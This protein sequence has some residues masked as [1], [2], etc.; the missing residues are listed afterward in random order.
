VRKVMGLLET[1]TA[2]ITGGG[3]GVGQAIAK[4]FHDEGAKVII[5]GRRE[6]KL[7]KAGVVIAPKGD[8][9]YSIGVDVTVDDD[10][11]RLVNFA[12]EK[13]GRI[14]IL[15]NNAAALYHG[16]LDESDPSL[17]DELMRTNAYAP[18]RLMVAVLPEMRKVGGGSI[19]NISSLAGIKAFPG[20]GLYGTSKAALQMLSQV[21]AME[22][23]SDNIRV[24]ILCP[25]VIKGTDIYKGMLT[26][27]QLFE[28]YD[29]IRSITP[30]GRLG[31]PKD[32]AEA[33]LFLASEQSSWVTGTI[34][35]LDG[36]R[37]LATNRPPS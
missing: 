11:R 15:V 13:T 34:F 8:R 17:W 14:D 25:A 22:V 4:R 6:E 18:W 12:V 9:F 36:G 24:N 23:A 26:E 29:D 2:I 5:C 37:H 32:V 7:R 3:S 10:L 16:K 31:E 21:M 19:I 35:N 27:E 1:K 33:A 28:Y 30:L 20:V